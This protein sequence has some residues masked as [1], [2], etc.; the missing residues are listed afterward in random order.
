MAYTK[1]I[2]HICENEFTR[3]G[4]HWYQSSCDYP[5]LSDEQKEIVTG[6]LMGDGCLVNRDGNPYLVVQCTK[7]EYLE[8]LDS[9]FGNISSGEPRLHITGEKLKKKY[10]DWLGASKDSEYSDQYRWQTR[11]IPGLSEFSSWYGDSGKVYPEQI[12][13]TPMT[14]THWYCGDG[15]YN[16]NGTNN[17]ISIGVSNEKTE[18]E[19]IENMFERKGLPRPN[20]WSEYEN[21]AEIVWNVNESKRLMEYMNDSYDGYEYKWMNKQ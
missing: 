3:L 5:E 11:G 14:L 1:D 16:N 13:L 8:R 15:N 4:S 18:K 7:R 10:G 17:Y 6:L 20:R 12:E 9:I 19:K 21:K 2:C